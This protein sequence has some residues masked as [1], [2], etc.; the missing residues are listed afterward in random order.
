MLGTVSE[1][2][3][4]VVIDGSE[5]KPSKPSNCVQWQKDFF[6]NAY[7]GYFLLESSLVGLAASW[8]KEVTEFPVLATLGK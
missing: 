8:P 2:W 7:F 3:C 5:N 1:S 6:F 4:K